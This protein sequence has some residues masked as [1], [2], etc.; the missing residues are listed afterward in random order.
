MNKRWTM[1]H[2]K[3]LNT[4]FKKYAFGYILIGSSLAFFLLLS[5]LAS[6]YI[7]MRYRAETEKMIQLNDLHNAISQMSENI[8][9]SYS[10]LSMEGIEE[11]PML[12]KDVEQCLIVTERQVTEH[13]N[14]EMADMNSVVETY[15]SRSDSLMEDIESY[16]K[17]SKEIEHSRISME[18]DI[19]QECFS[20]VGESFQNVYSAK[21]E[22]LNAVELNLKNVQL[23]IDV[24]LVL[25][26]IIIISAC[27]LYLIVMMRDISKSIRT[28]QIGVNSI[29]ENI[30]DAKPITLKSNDEFENLAEAYNSMLCII[31]TQMRKIAEDADMRERLSEAEKKNL[32]IYSDLQKNNLDFLQSRINPHFLFN[33]LNMISAQTRIEQ[34]DK[35]AELIELTASYLR[36]NLDNI[37]KTVTLEREVHNLRDYIAIQEYRYGD[38]FRFELSIDDKCLD[39]AIPCMVLQPLVENSIQHGVG[40]MMKD[41]YVNVR[42]FND[43]ERVILE[44]RDNGVGA[45]QERIE[46]IERN[47]RENTSSSTHIGIRNIYQRL[48]LYYKDDIT[49]QMK[50]ANPG[51]IITISLPYVRNSQG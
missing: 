34:A 35:S 36:Y 50:N 28:L 20:Y 12:K 22:Q 38:R 5:M 39:Q 43:K 2:K 9:M 30:A 44:I 40:M 51:L 29:E 4:V 23:A 48:R 42:A 37:K 10:F 46:E 3:M 32:Q 21:F 16:I 1:N 8:N 26:I 31:Q 25:F 13:Y 24:L 33:T 41:G 17:N 15:M 7:S 45:S 6:T 49:L 27:V 47:L 14:R 19:V 18:Y 11:Y